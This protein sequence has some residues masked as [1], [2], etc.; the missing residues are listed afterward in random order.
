MDISITNLSFCK[1]VALEKKLRD[2]GMQDLHWKEGEKFSFTQ[3]SQC[4]DLDP[5][6]Y[7]LNMHE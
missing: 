2:L 5:M 3:A 6:I 1:G 4:L 7:Y